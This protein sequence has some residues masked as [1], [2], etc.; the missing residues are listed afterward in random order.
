MTDA[1]QPLDRSIFGALKALAR[2]LFRLRVRDNP[3][4]C[5]TKHDAVQDMMAAWDMI[6][7]ATLVAGWDIYEGEPWDLDPEMPMLTH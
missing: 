4:L 5:R 3:T 2:Q 1:L 7:A 6:T